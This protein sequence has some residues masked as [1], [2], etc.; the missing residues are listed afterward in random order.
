MGQGDAGQRG[1]GGDASA[2]FDELTAGRA[3]GGVVSWVFHSPRGELEVDLSIPAGV[4]FSLES[5]TMI[6]VRGERSVCIGFFS[7]FLALGGGR[8][9]RF[10]M[11]GDG[12][13]KLLDSGWAFV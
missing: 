7:A 10:G 5:I 1:H 6:P 2:C 9:A 13:D 11:D 3:G 4:V 8:V 12:S